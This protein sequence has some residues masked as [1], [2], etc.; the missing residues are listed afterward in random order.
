MYKQTY[1]YYTGYRMH[2]AI[3]FKLYMLHIL[4]PTKP[5]ITENIPALLH[6]IVA[7]FM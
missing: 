2:C 7:T 1:T 3:F 5:Y 4:R 6:C